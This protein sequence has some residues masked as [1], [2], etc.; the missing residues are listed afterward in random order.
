MGKVIRNF[1]IAGTGVAATYGIMKA[2]AKKRT[3]PTDIVR[4]P[5]MRKRQVPYMRTKQPGQLM[6]G[7]LNHF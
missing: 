7:W 6:N 1:L 3:E 4:V 5:E 2:V